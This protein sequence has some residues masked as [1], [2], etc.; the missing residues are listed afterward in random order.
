MPSIY[1]CFMEK[2]ACQ[3]R[4]IYK[5]CMLMALQLLEYLIK[6]SSERVVDDACGHVSTIKMLPTSTLITKARMRG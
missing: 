3:W 6:N 5:A 1:A 2:E 4:Q